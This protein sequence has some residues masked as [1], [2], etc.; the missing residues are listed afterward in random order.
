[1]MRGV[2]NIKKAQEL[3]DINAKGKE[4]KKQIEAL[5]MQCPVLELE[6]LKAQL[7]SKQTYLAEFQKSITVD[8]FVDT[9]EMTEL[10]AQIE[11]FVPKQAQQAENTALIEKRREIQ[12]QLDALKLELAKVR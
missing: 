8:Q 5:Q 6:A 9:A 3:A 1:M 10:L 7:E 4:L 2:F 12:A 11:A